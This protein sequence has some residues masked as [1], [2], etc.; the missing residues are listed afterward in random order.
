MNKIHKIFFKK[1]HKKLLFLEAENKLLNIENKELRKNKIVD[2][3]PGL[4][5]PISFHDVNDDGKPPLFLD[6]LNE[7][8]RKIKVAELARIGRDEYF[9]KMI[10][11]TI[12]VLGNYAI[13][14][15]SDENMKN[16]RVGIIAIKM[17]RDFF[18]QVVAEDMENKKV[19]EFDEHSVLPE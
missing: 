16:G 12:N 5:L 11:Y 3:I 4:G 10:D 19:E 6:L 15:A 13:Q 9:N 1:I 8:E 7:K 2:Y 18:G 17:F 14:K